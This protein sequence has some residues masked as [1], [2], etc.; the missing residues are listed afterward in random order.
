MV[1]EERD[2]YLEKLDFY[3]IYIEEIKPIL[4][5]YENERRVLLLLEIL[6]ILFSITSLLIFIFGIDFIKFFIPYISDSFPIRP[7]F[8]VLLIASCYI[9]TCIPNNYVKKINKL[10]LP[11]LLKNN[12]KMS[13]RTDLFTD[14]E[15]RK[16]S[17][18]GFYEKKVEKDCFVGNYKGINFG[19]LKTKMYYWSGPHLRLTF[20]GIIL[21]IVNNKNFKNKT[22]VIDKKATKNK[23]LAVKIFFIVFFIITLLGLI[24]IKMNILSL[25]MLFSSLILL[26]AFYLSYTQPKKLNKS[27]LKDIELAKLYDIYYTDKNEVLNL[28]TQTFFEK[29]Q[30]LKTSFGCKNIQCSFYDDKIIFALSTNKKLFDIC[31]FWHSYKNNKSFNNFCNKM[32]SVYQII[33]QFKIN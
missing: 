9:A 3:N 26:Y 13:S 12:L 2:S 16:S 15:L 27:T 5:N 7:L 1:S 30:N 24:F 29:F 10:C 14:N 22:T 28:D 21:T 6:I 17:L 18:F 8:F 33:N 19:I 4:C 31:S 20:A 23:N 11:I 32:S 25:I